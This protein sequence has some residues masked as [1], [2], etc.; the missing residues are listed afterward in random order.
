ME[1]R[2]YLSAQDNNLRGGVAVVLRS[3]GEAGSG[4]AHLTL[5]EDGGGDL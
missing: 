3:V 2:S 5:A 4:P 1:H